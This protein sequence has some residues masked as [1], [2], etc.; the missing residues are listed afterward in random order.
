MC[1]LFF[2]CSPSDCKPFLF[3]FFPQAVFSEPPDINEARLGVQCLL[4]RSSSSAATLGGGGGDGGA[5]QVRAYL[6]EEGIMPAPS[7]EPSR[8]PRY[9]AKVD[10]DGDRGEGSGLAGEEGGG[11]PKPF[12][13]AW[14]TTTELCVE[15]DLK[16]REKTFE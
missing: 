2:Q 12:A 4:E 6:F 8:H 10:G 5:I 3:L 1:T 7:T 15:L 9:P 16:A 13:E 11:E 14:C